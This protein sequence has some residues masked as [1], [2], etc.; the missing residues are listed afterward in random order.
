MALGCLGRRRWRRNRV[1]IR[2]EEKRGGKEED[3]HFWRY[4]GFMWMFSWFRYVYTDTLYIKTLLL[5]TA[6][7]ACMSYLERL[8]KEG[9]SCIIGMCSPIHVPLDRAL[10][11]I[12]RQYWRPLPL[13]LLS[14]PQ[15]PRA[16]RIPLIRVSH[17]RFP[18]F[19]LLLTSR[20]LSHPHSQPRGVCTLYWRSTHPR[21]WRRRQTGALFQMSR[22]THVKESQ[23]QTNPRR[24]HLS[25]QG[26][27]E[28]VL[29]VATFCAYP[30]PNTYPSAKL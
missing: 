19:I 8:V 22:K 10:T 3:M 20:S 16:A 28:C 2:W 18:L 14:L 13:P 15:F 21:P 29:L 4:G 26:L 27:S 11:Y 7:L 1:G 12:A 25:Q 24:Q 17:S 30:T 9:E 23:Q 5:Q 6:H